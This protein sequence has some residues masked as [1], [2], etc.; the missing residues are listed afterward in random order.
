[1]TADYQPRERP[2]PPP[3]PYPLP[4]PPDIFSALRRR[5]QSGQR[6]GGVNPFDW[7][8]SCSPSVKVNWQLQSL[9]VNVVSGK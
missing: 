4:P 2:R 6:V 8:N 1:M 7:K 9:Q 5:R 3:P